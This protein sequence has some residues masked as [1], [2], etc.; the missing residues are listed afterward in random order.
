MKQATY[1]RYASDSNTLQ[2][3]LDKRRRWLDRKG[4]NAAEFARTHED[5]RNIPG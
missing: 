4:K 3:K 5:A 2:R 1:D